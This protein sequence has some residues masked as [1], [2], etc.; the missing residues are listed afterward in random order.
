V[1]LVLSK[2]NSD[3]VLSSTAAVMPFST[4]CSDTFYG[5]TKCLQADP[6]LA[7]ERFRHII[8]DFRYFFQ[9]FFCQF[10]FVKTRSETELSMPRM[11]T[12]VLCTGGPALLCSEE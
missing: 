5:Q 2:K 9:I 3:D 7:A 6:K 11:S 10:F 12:L 8:F 4:V 1:G